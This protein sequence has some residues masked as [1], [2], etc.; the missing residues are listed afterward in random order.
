MDLKERLGKTVGEIVEQKLSEGERKRS[1]YDALK[2]GRKK[3]V[4][5]IAELKFSS[6]GKGTIRPKGAE[7]K[8]ILGEFESGGASAVSVLVEPR[9]FMG[10]M[11]FLRKARDV[12]DLPILAKGFF[13]SPMHLAECALSGADSYL[14]MVR[15]ME[16]LGA[17]FGD[18]VYAGRMLGM[19]PFI[20]AE[21]RE[22]IEKALP[23]S[24]I[25]SV[26]NR[27]IYGDLK[28]DPGRA[29]AGKGL[30]GDKVFVSSSGI[31]SAE[32]LRKVCEL[33]GFRVDAVLV[34]TALMRSAEIS[35]KI[36]ELVNAGSEV[37]A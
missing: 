29:A 26:N 10:E 6:P 14:L 18:L 37:A 1:M 23:N 22:E 8:E 32:D 5:V 16:V 4:R 25:I 20:E 21:T 36:E 31:S 24:R 15:I 13:F 35:R 12:T 17:D 19:E 30:S 7:I 11:E 3:G 34:G 2:N 28:I 33:S 27:E 9:H